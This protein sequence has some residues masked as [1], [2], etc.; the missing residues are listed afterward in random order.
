MRFGGSNRG[1]LGEHVLQVSHAPFSL[2]LA[3][4]DGGDVLGLVVFALDTENEREVLAQAL[5]A[6]TVFLGFP[7]K[8]LGLLGLAVQRIGQRQVVDHGCRV[9]LL[10]QGRLIV[11]LGLGMV[12]PLGGERALSRERLPVF[13]AFLLGG[14]ERLGGDADLAGLER[15]L[16]DFGGKLRIVRIGRVGGL[17]YFE[18]R[19]LF[20]SVRSAAE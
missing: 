12:A 14:L 11:L 4:V 15:D 10:P 6:A 20:P 13:D 18:A 8:G 5:V 3:D 2:G 17:Q 16:A 9:R 1:R 7:K 19:F